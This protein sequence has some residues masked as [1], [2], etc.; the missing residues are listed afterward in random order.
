MKN[1]AGIVLAAGLGTRMKSKKPK[2]F[3]E[4]AGKPMIECI[5]DQLD[6]LKLSKIVIVVGNKESIGAL[7]NRSHIKFVIQKEKKGTAHAVKQA[8]K[9]LKDFKGDIIILNGDVPLITAETLENLVLQHRNSFAKLSLLTAIVDNPTGYGRIVR[10]NNEI[11]RITEELDADDMTRQ[12]KEINAG[13]YCFKSDKL[14]EVLAKI[15]KNP[16]KGEYYLTDAIEILIREGSKVHTYVVPDN[17]EILGVNRRFELAKANK[18][19]QRRI[20]EKLL[21]NGVTIIDMD[22]TYIEYDVEVGQDTII[23]PF[24]FLVGKTKIGENSQI[25][26]FAHITESSLGANSKVF[27]STIVNSKLKDFVQVGPFSHIRGNTVLQ[28]NVEIG[29]F[30]EI[31]RS[32]IGEGT[33]AYHLSYIGDTKT[34]ADV[35]FGA[36]I[37]TANFDGKKKNKTVIEDKAYIGSGT[38]IIAPAK[39]KKGEFV[40]NG[41]L[42]K[43][44][45]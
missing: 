41:S 17:N 2:V 45:K 23:Y 28:N 12:I 26:P 42:I 13:T 19:M 1:L 36:G 22:N 6:K 3:H 33:K 7:S 5:I 44:K 18:I 14:F 32:N 10:K 31:T 39:I 40:D 43:K 11:I 30:V 35:N 4:V 24:T 21:N 37:V 34:G 9:E 16:L 38:T 8:E 25:G 20:Q 15:K 27:Q 29:N